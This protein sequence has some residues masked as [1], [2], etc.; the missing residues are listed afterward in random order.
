MSGYI[1]QADL[2]GTK[3]GRRRPDM[4]LI[5]GRYTLDLMGNH[6]RLQIRDWAELRLEHHIPFSWE[7]DTWY[8]MKLRVDV[9]NG[10]AAVLGK[11]WPKAQKEP[12]GW[13]IRVEDPYPN[14]TGSPG[15]YGYSP[16]TIYYDN[17][18]VTETKQ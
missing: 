11:V 13:T 7:V 4:G 8:T 15:L 9:K 17:I 6:Q 5:A 14:P 2:R 1:I 16:T 18:K 12:D 10:K 3:K